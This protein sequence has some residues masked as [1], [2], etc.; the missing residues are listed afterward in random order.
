MLVDLKSSIINYS[1]ADPDRESSPFFPFFWIRDDFFRIP[2]I[3]DY[4]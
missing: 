4:D 1:V 3:F 2:D